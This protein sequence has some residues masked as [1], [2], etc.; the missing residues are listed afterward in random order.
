MDIATKSELAER[1]FQLD[2]KIDKCLLNIRDN[3]LE[4][5]EIA[6]KLKQNKMYKLVCPEAK[7]WDHYISLRFTGIKRAQLDNYSAVSSSLGF[8]LKDRD[9]K[10]T[11]AIDILR[12]VK[13][14]PEPEQKAKIAELIESAETLPKSGWESAVAV[15]T[16]KVPPD[17]C[18]HLEQDN[19]SRCKNCGRFFKL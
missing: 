7:T 13:D 11:R 4:L 5:G 1:A 9:V 12:I 14:L 17:G 8:Y 19:W 3:F 2:R 6:Y 15:E 16:G 18:E 10:I